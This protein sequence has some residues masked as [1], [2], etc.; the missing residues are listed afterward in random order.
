MLWK[1]CPVIGNAPK[2]FIRIYEYG[3]A[4]KSN[5]QKWTAYI[6]KIGHKWYP[7]ESITEQLMTLIGQVIGIKVA[8]SK[9]MLVKG[10]LRFLSKYFLKHDDRL[11]HGSEIFSAYFGDEDFVQEVD[12]ANK[13]REIFTFQ[14]IK[15]AIHD[16]YPKYADSLIESFVEMLFFDAVAGNNDRHFEN[17]GVIDNIKKGSKVEL[18][19]VYDT[20]HGLFWNYHESNI[21][22]FLRHES[23][24]NS[25]IK[26]SLP[27]TGW[28]NEKDLNHFELLQR[29]VNEYPQYCELIGKFDPEKYQKDTH[30]LLNN[31]FREFFSSKRRY[32]IEKCITKRAILIQKLVG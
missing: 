27:A 2:D 9:L 7:N 22:S 12:E 19:P 11:V 30:R 32:L 15:N 17:W 28:D 23:K 21:G 24:L 18:S 4:R 13:A 25:Y 29:V 16:V 10:Q 3:M 1:T 26:G 20:A 8:D 5:P 14:S 31:E 6:A